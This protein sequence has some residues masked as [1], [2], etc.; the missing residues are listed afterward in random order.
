MAAIGITR[1]DVLSGH[2]LLRYLQPDELRK[3][4]TDAMLARHP[5]HVTIFQKGDPGDSMMAVVRGRVKICTYSGEGR[6][7]VLNIIDHGGLFG[8]IALLDGQ[9]RTADAVTLEET[10]ILVLERRRL[11]PFLTA[12]PEITI[13]LISVI[14]KRL[15]QTSE[16]LEDALLREAPSRLARGLLRLAD[17]FGRP[18]PDGMRLNIKLSQQQIG[19]LIGISRE[20]INKHI[21]DWSR[22]GHLAVHGGFITIRDREAIEEIAEA[23]I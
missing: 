13:R 3:L 17:T 8:E 23:E 12:N 19:N 4:A 21:V 9:P 15:R 2:F 7:L 14:C 5:A 22:A 18:A 6:E 1:E 10:D 16:H 11:L 20:S